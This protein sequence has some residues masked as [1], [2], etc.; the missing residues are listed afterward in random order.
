LNEDVCDTDK[1]DAKAQVAEAQDQ[2]VNTHLL[3]LSSKEVRHK[4]EGIID[5]IHAIL[6][7]TEGGREVR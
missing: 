1:C 6:L 2:E 4:K 3:R 5:D 7:G